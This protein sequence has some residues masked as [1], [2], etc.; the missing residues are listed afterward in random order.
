MS[1]LTGVSGDMSMISEVP[2]VAPM[3]V[4][5][6]QWFSEFSTPFG[7]NFVKNGEQKPGLAIR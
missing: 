5:W 4:L 2:T 7:F 6:G 1:G 3:M